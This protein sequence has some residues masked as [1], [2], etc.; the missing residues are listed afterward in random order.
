MNFLKSAAPGKVLAPRNQ[1]IFSGSRPGAT[2]PACASM[3][4]AMNCLKST[5][6]GTAAFHRFQRI[7]TSRSTLSTAGLYDLYTRY[8][9]S[10]DKKATFSRWENYPQLPPQPQGPIYRGF[11][12]HKY[13]LNQTD[14]PVFHEIWPYHHHHALDLYPDLKA[15]AAPCRQKSGLWTVASAE[16]G[17]AC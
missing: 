2:Q 4:H 5:G 10:V 14:S 6:Q 15:R 16:G 7:Q 8:G 1:R 9:Q 3:T 13:H 17:S 12:V 11:Q